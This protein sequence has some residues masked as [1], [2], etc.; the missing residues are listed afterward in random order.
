M[1]T[2]III[3]IFPPS[4][5]TYHTSIPKEPHRPETLGVSGAAFAWAAALWSALLLVGCGPLLLGWFTIF[6]RVSETKLC[7]PQQ[8]YVAFISYYRSIVIE[9]K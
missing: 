9:A 8:F 4:K 1:I 3:Q 7:F 2:L 6:D 5:R